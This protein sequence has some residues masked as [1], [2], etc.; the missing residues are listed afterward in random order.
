V[1]GVSALVAGAWLAAP[2]P[3]GAVCGDG[4]PEQGEACDDGNT[5][6]C[7]GCE[8]SCQPAHC[9]N[10]V[11]DCCEECDDGN[12]VD[13]DGCDSV[14]TFDSHG[15]FSEA[16]T[17]CAYELNRLGALVAKAQSADNARC[18]RRAARGD[19]PLADCLGEDLAGA[20]RRQ[21]CG[22][23]RPMPSSARRGRRRPSVMSVPPQ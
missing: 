1:L 18:L 2:S 9:G 7:D 15:H 16:E 17:A 20:S 10:G 22:P 5:I 19:L 8:P 6:E 12:T 14:C 3:A 13:G 11:V 4:L 23:R 21:R